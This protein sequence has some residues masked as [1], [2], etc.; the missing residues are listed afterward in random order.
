MITMIT[1]LIFSN[2]VSWLAIMALGIT[3]LALVRQVGLLHE[4]ISPAGALS[5][6]KKTLLIGEAAPSFNLLSITGGRISLGGHYPHE[7]ST[8]LFFLSDTC[9]VCK[10]LL[11]IIKSIAKQ[12]SPWLRIVLAS[13]G[14]VVAAPKAVA[15]QALSCRLSPGLVP[16]ETRETVATILFPTT[17]A[18]VRVPV[19]AAPACAMK[20]IHRLI[21]HKPPI[22]LIG[23]RAAQ[24]MWC[25]TAPPPSYW[26][27]NNTLLKRV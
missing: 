3:V 25:T 16:V 13:D 19:A 11:P 21:S 20:M 6:D 9:P 7:K 27:L 4:R 23:V 24:P 1:T 2:I 22:I 14:A 12:E 10:T 26:A 17:I 15:R 18:A 8:L 5:I